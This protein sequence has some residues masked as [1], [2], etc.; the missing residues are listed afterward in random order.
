[1]RGLVPDARI[2]QIK[3][4][5]ALM[6]ALPRAARVH[7]DINGWQT[8]D[9]EAAPPYDAAHCLELIET[10]VTARILRLKALPSAAKT[11]ASIRTIR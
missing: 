5:T 11:A 2:D 1:V 9:G 4:G 8:V 3:R 6:I 10:A 7:W